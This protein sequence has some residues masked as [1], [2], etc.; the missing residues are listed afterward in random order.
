MNFQDKRLWYAIA[1]VVVV[2]ILIW[3]AWPAGEMPTAPTTPPACAHAIDRATSS[4]EGLFFAVPLRQYGASDRQA[5]GGVMAESN[6]RLEGEWIKN[7]NC[8][9]GCPCDFNA[10][11]TNG[12][13]EGLLGMRITKGHFED[14]KLDGLSFFVTVAFPGPCTRATAKPSRSSTS[15][16]ARRSARRCSRSC[17]GRTRRK[18]RCSTSSA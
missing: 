10:R 5:G 1:A 7:C 4:F 2:L 17:P 9:F 18:E 16:P 8:A 6:W 13:C 15:G 11:P 3:V 12:E 14:V